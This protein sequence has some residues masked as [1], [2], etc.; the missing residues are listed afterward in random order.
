[1][2]V[3]L[4]LRNICSK[5]LVCCA[6]VLF[7]FLS[8]VP[9]VLAQQSEAESAVASVKQ[10]IVTCYLV[11]KEAEAAGANISLLTV[12]LNE[13][14]DLLS[15]A[16]LA[17]LEGN[18]DDAISFTSQSQQELE[19]FATDANVLRYQA[20]QER[21]FDFLVYVVGTIVGLLAVFSGGFGAWFL[22]K[23]HFE[24]SGV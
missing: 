19:S 6:L 18:F 14:A 5:A 21:N 15:S 20:L 24:Q 4:R 12:K 3:R 8:A 1:M 23:K 13:A 7:A 9:L 22:L 16:E 2:R 11:A 17:Y 10:Q